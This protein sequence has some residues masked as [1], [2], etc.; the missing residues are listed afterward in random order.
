[1]GQKPNDLFI[2]WGCSACHA[3]VDTH[4]DDATQIA[5]AQAVFRTQAALLKMGYE[6]G[7]KDEPR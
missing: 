5:F 4:K 6:L 1:M 2:A 3:Y 7:T